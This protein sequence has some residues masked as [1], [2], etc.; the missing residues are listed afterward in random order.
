M[1]FSTFQR[2]AILKLRK[3]KYYHRKTPIFFWKC[4]FYM[5]YIF[6]EKVLISNKISFGEKAISTLLVTCIM[7]IKLNH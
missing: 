7:I 2:F 3:N 1:G 4:I 6:I 5:K